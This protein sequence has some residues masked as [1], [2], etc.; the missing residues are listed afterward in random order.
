MGPA[1]FEWF[2]KHYPGWSAVYQP[3]WEGYAQML[4]P[5]C[6]HLMLQEL[7]SLPPFCQVCR[8]PCAM[9]HP[10]ANEFQLIEVDGQQWPVCSEG[11]AWMMSTWPGA[12]KRGRQ[13]WANYHG[14]DLADVIV[15]L[16]LIRP[17]GKTL[18][19]QPSLDLERL[20]TID[21]IRRI[22]YEV[23]DPLHGVL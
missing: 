23:K 1:D 17:D 2:E 10:G 22:G 20:W 13:L 21:D 15:D 16:G 8:L 6:G 18:M 12:Y 5:S 9:P 19:G 7:P 14:W 4:D 3:F 11:C